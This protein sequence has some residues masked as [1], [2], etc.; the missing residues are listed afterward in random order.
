MA[1][2][3]TM[4]F[5]FTLGS[6]PQGLGGTYDEGYQLA[7]KHALFQWGIQIRTHTYYNGS[8]YSNP[9]WHTYADIVKTVSATNSTPFTTWASSDFDAWTVMGPGNHTCR[10]EC[11]AGALSMLIDGLYLNVYTGSEPAPQVSPPVVATTAS[12][13]RTGVNPVF[14]KTLSSGVRNL[15]S[16]GG[17][18]MTPS[19][20]FW[21]DF[22]IT[23]EI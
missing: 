7:M 8:N 9:T 14:T 1:S 10:F 4:Q 17:V 13:L 6:P 16:V 12:D 3:Y 2:T 18:T 22:I 21:R 19:P 23:A 5:P 11:T 15:L 20:V